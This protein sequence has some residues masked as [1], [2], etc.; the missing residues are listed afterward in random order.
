M[1]GPPVSC[2]YEA[3]GGGACPRRAA[4]KLTIRDMNAPASISGEPV[5]FFANCCLEHERSTRA[6]LPDGLRVET[7]EAL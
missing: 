7:R 3:A 5:K 6:T 1:S 2:D 4:V